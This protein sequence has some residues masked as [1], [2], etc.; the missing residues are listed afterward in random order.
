MIKHFKAFEFRVSRENLAGPCSAGWQQF[1]SSFANRPSG[2]VHPRR[3]LPA[4]AL[5][6]LLLLVGL[7]AQA[8]NYTFQGLNIPLGCTGGNGNFTCVALILGVG[9]TISISSPTTITI[10]LAG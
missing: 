8:A 10:I 4:L 3:C 7:P 5:F 2:N 9:D 6:L 1:L